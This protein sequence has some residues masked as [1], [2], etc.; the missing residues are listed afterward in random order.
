[1]NPGEFLPGD[2]REATLLGRI[3]FGE[4]PTPVLVRDGRVAD[5]SRIAPTTAELLNLFSSRTEM[6]RGE[7][8]GSFA[9]LDFRPAWALDAAQ[10]KAR[11]LSPI[12]LQCVKA[13]GVTFAVSTLERVIEERA[14]GDLTAAD[15]I[16]RQL[17]D[18]IG[19]D[20]KS[21]RPG[22]ADAAKL[23]DA[24]IADGLW[25]QYLEVAI[26]P[27]AEVFTKA[28][29]LAS[30]G[31]GDFVGVR[32]DSQ[33][34]NPEPEIVVVCDGPAPTR[35]GARQRREPARLRRPLGAPPRQGE[36]QQRLGGG[37]PFRAALRHGVHAR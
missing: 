27:D 10:A 3:D 22:S 32:A 2:W 18:R 7:D 31:W 34:N 23:K 19:A 8:R 5:V 14:R 11:L 25:S 28:P 26:G 21:V 29:T 16:R 37:R 15:K 1:M 24:L 4:G 30:V 6:P 33:W 20:L 9:D 35:C 13:A 12:D 17:A 36:G